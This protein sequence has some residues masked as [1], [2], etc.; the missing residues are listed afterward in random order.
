MT[1]SKRKKNALQFRTASP[2][3]LWHNSHVR[4]SLAFLQTNFIW[5]SFRHGKYIINCGG[6]NYFRSDSGG[7]TG[8]INIKVYYECKVAGAF[9]NTYSSARVINLSTLLQFHVPNSVGASLL[10]SQ[11]SAVAFYFSTK[12]R[13]SRAMLLSCIWICSHS[14]VSAHWSGT[15]NGT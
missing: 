11:W 10:L 8:M 2:Q 13:R 6:G 5:N 14:S 3:L 1:S 15:I 7:K 12:P 9:E 4:V